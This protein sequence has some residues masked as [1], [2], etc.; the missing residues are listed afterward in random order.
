MGA[1]PGTGLRSEHCGLGFAS[2]YQSRQQVRP[3]CRIHGIITNGGAAANII[4]EYA[5]AV[6]YVRAPRI[7]LMW[8]TYRRVVA[9][10][11]GAAQAAGCAGQHITRSTEWN[12]N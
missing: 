8:D 4:P 10:A 11:E 1:A 2:R 9:C 6:F 7:D 3:E 5:S 12:T